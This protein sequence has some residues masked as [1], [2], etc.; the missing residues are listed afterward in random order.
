MNIRIFNCSFIAIERPAIFSEIM[1]LLMAGTGVG[2]SVQHRH[3]NK[4]PDIKTP[5]RSKKYVIEELKNIIVQNIN[6]V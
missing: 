1:V 2:Y 5:K 3:I 4:L 6:H